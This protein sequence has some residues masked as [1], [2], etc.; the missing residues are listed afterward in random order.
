MQ[1]CCTG[2]MACCVRERWETPCPF[3]SLLGS[4]RTPWACSWL[5]RKTVKGLK[6]FLQPRKEVALPVE[7]HYLKQWSKPS[8]HSHP[9][10]L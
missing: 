3:T 6:G 1:K 4:G 7:D 8:F 9:V 5:E 2:G 10:V